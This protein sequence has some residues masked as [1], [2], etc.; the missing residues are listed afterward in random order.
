MHKKADLC[1]VLGSSLR[2]SPANEIPKIVAQRGQS[3]VIC[4]LQKTPLDSF[5]KIHVHAKCDTFMSRVMHY[6]NLEIPKFIL[7]R[8]VILST[9]DNTLQISSVDI[10]GTLVTLF[11]KVKVEGKTILPPYR[12]KFKSLPEKANVKIN[13]SFMGHY[14]EP[15]LEIEHEIK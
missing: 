13:F 5:A 8:R 6:L 4:N 2:V 3:L 12:V 15:D 9:F 14:G 7:T 11:R 10:D 1:I